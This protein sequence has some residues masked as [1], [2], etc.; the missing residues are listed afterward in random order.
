MAS[1]PGASWGGSEAA[2]GASGL[3]RETEAAAGFPLPAAVVSSKGF[4]SSVWC[5]GAGG[6]VLLPAM[7]ALTARS[8]CRRMTLA[9]SLTALPRVRMVTRVSN[10]LIHSKSS[11]VK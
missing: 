7:R 8:T 9:L 1:C 5:A 2:G 3:G 11:G 6:V 4:R 10:S